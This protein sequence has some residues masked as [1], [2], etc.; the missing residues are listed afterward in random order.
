MKVIIILFYISTLFLN[1]DKITDKKIEI[2]KMMAKDNI[3]YV[4]NPLIELTSDESMIKR[5]PLLKD[6]ALRGNTKALRLLGYQKLKLHDQHGLILL[7]EAAILGDFIATKDLSLIPNIL[8]ITSDKINISFKKA[9]DRLY[10]GKVFENQKTPLLTNKL[11]A[12]VK[13]FNLE[14]NKK[15]ITY[16]S[17]INSLNK[18]D[19]LIL[20]QAS[21]I[22]QNNIQEKDMPIIKKNKR[23]KKE[24]FALTNAKG[25][26][27]AI[28]I[29]NQNRNSSALKLLEKTPTNK[30][31]LFKTK[32][33]QQLLLI[34]MHR[35]EEKKISHKDFWEIVEKAQ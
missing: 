11:K 15:N 7:C 3:D 29:R 35:T 21:K 23:L 26:E 19:D 28:Q 24:T 17:Y 13:Q 6:A 1:A 31:K 34:N 9:V 8:N 30:L 5:E 16:F 27:K 22:Y 4:Y 33:E 12:K 10:E 2:L 14:K 18:E 32:I 20:I 25:E